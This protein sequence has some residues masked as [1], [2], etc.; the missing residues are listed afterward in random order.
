MQPSPATSSSTPA[1]AG[2]QAAL[3][4]FSLRVDALVAE[5]ERQSAAYKVLDPK[6]QRAWQEGLAEW[7]S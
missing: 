3:E 6:L 5:T 7:L 1:R 2:S 4:D